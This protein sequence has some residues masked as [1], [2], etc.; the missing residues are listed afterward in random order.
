ME[1][2]QVAAKPQVKVEPQVAAKPQVKAEPTVKAEPQVKAAPLDAVV[3]RWFGD[4]FP[5]S[6]VARDVDAYNYVHGAVEELKKRLKA[7]PTPD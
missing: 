7:A 3:D 6:V 4:H 1:D 5:G 2:D